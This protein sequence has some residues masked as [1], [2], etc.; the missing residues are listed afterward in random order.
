[1]Q[2]AGGDGFG[3]TGLEAFEMLGGGFGFGF[4]DLA[5][6]VYELFGHCGVFGEEE[7][8]GELHVV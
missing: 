6:V 3:E 5:F 1:M 7:V 8:L 4:A 2:G